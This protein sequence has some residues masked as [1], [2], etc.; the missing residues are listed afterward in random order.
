[1]FGSHAELTLVTHRF[2]FDIILIFILIFIH[3]V[4]GIAAAMWVKM[5]WFDNMSHVE[6]NA[7]LFCWISK[8]W[9]I[10]VQAI[11]TYVFF[12]FLIIIKVLVNSSRFI[13]IPKFWVYDRYEYFNFFSEGTVFI[14]QNLTDKDG[15]RKGEG[16]IF[17]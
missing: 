4:V 15:P 2:L 17:S 16:N 11:G 6:S 14:R 9:V 5:S 3:P 13:W 10:F 1:M 12:Q 8:C 7:S